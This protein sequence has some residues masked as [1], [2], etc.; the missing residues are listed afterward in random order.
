MA[1]KSRRLVFHLHVVGVKAEFSQCE[2][3]QP[4][5]DQ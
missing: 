3:T 4:Q 2:I 5:T 1:P